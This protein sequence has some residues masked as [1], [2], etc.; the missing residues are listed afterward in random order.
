MA[1]WRKRLDHASHHWDPEFASRSLHVG[2]LGARNRVWVGF[3]RGSSH[4][5]LPP[6]SFHH[7]STHLIN[8]INI[9]D[10]ASG[11]VGRHPCYSLTYNIVT[12]P[13]STRPCVGHELRIFILFFYLLT[14]FDSRVWW[15]FETR[16]PGVKI[17]SHS[18]VHIK[19]F[20][21]WKVSS[22]KS[23]TSRVE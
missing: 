23:N 22:L 7:F 16:F 17:P 15:L 1:S 20:R 19:N 13:P 5:P 9:C 12:F 10:G 8:F 11:V 6:I 4:F 2:F 3:S 21:Q 14:Q 18:T